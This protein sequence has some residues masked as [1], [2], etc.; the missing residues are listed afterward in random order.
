MKLRP[1]ARAV[2]LVG[3]MG[4]GKSA[5]GA[6][7]ARE[8][9]LPLIETDDLIAAAA[10]QSIARIFAEDGEPAF[11]DLETAAVRSAAQ[12]E[13][14]VIS[15]GGGAVLREENLQALQAAG[16]VVWLQASPETILE[17]TRGSDR[18]LLQVA[19]PRAEIERLLSE[20]EPAYARADGA[21]STEGLAPA[22]V[23]ERL[24]AW[25]AQDARAAY[26]LGEPIRVPVLLREGGYEVHVG[27]G[28]LAGLGELLPPPQAGAR[29]A[30]IADAALLETYAATAVAALTAG[31][32]DVTLHAVPSGEA[33]KNLAL[34]G[35][36]CAELAA[37]GH[38]R[39]SWVFAVGGG[40]TTDLGG[41]VAA[42]F[43]RGLP[44]V[45]VPTTLLAQVDAAVGGKVAVNLPQGKNLVGAFHQPRAV[46]AEVPALSTLPAAEWAEGLAEVIKH[47][48]LADREMFEYLESH[49]SEVRAGQ[50]RGLQYLVARNCQIKAEVVA[51]DPEERDW[52]AVLNFGHTLGHALER[53]AEGWGLGHGAAVALGMLAETRWAERCDLTPAGISERLAALLVQA[54]LP[55]SAAGVDLERARQALRADKKL[56][57]G[58]L[59][60]PVLTALGEVRLEPGVSLADLE[61]ALDF[62]GQ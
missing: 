26:F 21:V 18:P 16:P 3:F 2:T 39:G 23:G 8:L 62:V 41:F 40:V 25:L 15:T 1:P 24:R 58:R 47:A 56:R 22:Q 14:A 13:G 53:G 35:E 37:A 50:A 28:L 17:R 48:T 7:L 11:R 60:L 57:G 19:D 29:T 54:G 34:A 4:S 31:G 5:T 6:W 55:T 43:M 10:G 59:A 38:D 61:P 33:S 49:L 9:G 36:L 45:T 44:L 30:V 32:W 12:A 51:R 27:S 52:R 20:R 42:I 46:V